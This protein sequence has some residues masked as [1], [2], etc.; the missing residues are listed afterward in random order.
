MHGDAKQVSRVRVVLE[1]DTLCVH[2]AHESDDGDG[3]DY[4][5]THEPFSRI[6]SNCTT[7]SS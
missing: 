2:S 4:N 3:D 1:R 7:R 5:T 6:L